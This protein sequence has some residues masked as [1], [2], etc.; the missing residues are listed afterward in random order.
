MKILSTILSFFLALTVSFGQKMVTST[1]VTDNTIKIVYADQLITKGT[2]CY[3]NFANKEV[4]QPTTISSGM[5]LP[6]LAWK[7]AQGILGS[8]DQTSL[9]PILTYGLTIGTNGKIEF[10]PKRGLHFIVSQSGTTTTGA[11]I[12]LPTAINAYILANLSHSYFFGY[13]YKVTRVGTAT[14]YTRLQFGSNSS[15]TANFLFLMQKSNVRPYSVIGVANRL[16]VRSD[17]PGNYFLV[18]DHIVTMGVSAFTGTA[19]GSILTQFTTFL[20][21]DSNIL[22]KLYVEDLTV[23]GRTYADA[24]AAFYAQYQAD[25]ASGG[26]YFGDTTPTDPTTIP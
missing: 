19:G 4:T 16:G 24:D 17:G 11:T 12:A 10:T 2:L 5:V 18:G 20:Q 22:Y 23:S 15:P 6:N 21:S 14:D 25:L 1:E 7:V 8:G 13:Q 26:Q 3:I 9:S